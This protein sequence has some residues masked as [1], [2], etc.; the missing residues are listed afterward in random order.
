MKVE[1][2]GPVCPECDKLAEN[3][4]RAVQELGV[5]A[6]IIRIT[7]IEEMTRRGVMITPALAVDGEVKSAGKVLSSIEIADYLSG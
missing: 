6:E 2:L 7:D 4:Q 1:I 3:A 5:D